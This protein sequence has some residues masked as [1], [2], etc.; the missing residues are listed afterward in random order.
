MC[1]LLAMSSR[2]PTQLTRSLAALAAHAGGESRN[3]DGWGVG[4]YQ[5]R[6]VALF[7]EPCAASDSEL[8]RLLQ[9]QG[10]ST[11]LIVGHL[12][13]AT[14][15]AV[16]LANTG[17]FARE[18]NGR[19]RIFAHNGNLGGLALSAEF[20]GGCYRAIG[21]SDSEQA[22]C[23]LLARLRLLES[24]RSELPTVQERL[25]LIGRFAADLRQFGSANFLYSDGDALF[26][27]ADRRF[28]A[29]NGKVEAPALYL[30]HCPVPHALL[31]DEPDGA[32]RVTFLASV[33]LSTDGW[34]PM[35]EGEVVALRDGVVVERLLLDKRRARLI[36]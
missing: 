23:A 28:N 36:P 27:H 8:V 20:D 30:W 18:L 1:E 26:A 9:I 3:R 16:N 29:L 19:M 2:L 12:R 22:F 24:Q 25:A 14:Q 5:G 33:P 34:L 6:D 10:P 15:G 32:Q 7:K 11:T 4:F 17:P 21:E 31:Q 13:H 35:A